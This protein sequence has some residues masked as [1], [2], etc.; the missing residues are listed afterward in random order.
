MYHTPEAVLIP[1]LKREW[2]AL[3]AKFADPSDPIHAYL[4]LPETDDIRK[5]YAED[6]KRMRFVESWPNDPA[7]MPVV[8]V[9]E[10]EHSE[11]TQ[12]EGHG[13]DQTED[14]G[15]QQL[16]EESR[17]SF[18]RTVSIEILTKNKDV[19]EHYMILMRLILL[20]ARTELDNGLNGIRNQRVQGVM[21]IVR[22][23]KDFPEDVWGRT[24]MFSYEHDEVIQTVRPIPTIQEF[25]LVK[26]A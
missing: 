24:I 7:K 11:T 16:T 15:A 8:V 5:E 14:A 9:E 17:F 6:R 25:E 13:Y 2:D 12:Y 10:R 20:N 21:G 4:G 26:S 23:I 18:R 19:A 3:K 22:D 1:I